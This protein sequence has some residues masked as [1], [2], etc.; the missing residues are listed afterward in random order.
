MTD[1]KLTDE[2]LLDWIH[3]ELKDSHSALNDWRTEAEKCYDM[4]ASKQWDEADEKQLE[5]NNRV[6]VTFNRIARTINAVAG[7]EIQNRQEIRYYPRQL[8][9][10]GVNAMLTNAA[11]WV[12]DR[13][14]AEDEESEMFSDCL[15]TGMGWIEYPLEDE[16]KEINV[17]TNRL[18]P[19]EML[20]DRKAKKKNLVDSLWRAKLKSISEDDLIERWPDADLGK[21][22]EG[23][24]YLE[25]SI[26][27]RDVTPPRYRKE[28]EKPESARLDGY[29]VIEFQW[30]ENEPYYQVLTEGGQIAE[31]TPAKWDKVKKYAEQRGLRWNKRKRKVFQCAYVCGRALLQREPVPSQDDFTLQCITGLR[32]RNT[33]TWFGLVTLMRDPQRWANKWLSQILHIVNVNAKGGLLAEAD[34]FEDVAKAEA[35][36][37]ASDTI[38]WMRQGGLQKIQERSFGQ[39]PPGVD[40]LLQYALQA[41]TDVP[42]VNAEMLGLVDRDQPGIL[43]EARKRA[44]ITIISMFFDA[45]RRYRKAAGHVLAGL[46]RDYIADGRLIRILGPQGEQYVP[47]IRDPLTAEY[48]IVVDESP[49]S[50][51]MK[52][53]A[54]GAL[55]QI[56]PMAIQAGIRVPPE[57]IDYTPLPESLIAKWKEL[58]SPRQPDPK[59]AAEAEAMKQLSFRQLSANAAETEAKAQYLLAQ[60][61]EKMQSAGLQGA[62][63]AA[64]ERNN[65]HELSI[66]SLKAQHEIQMLR[67]KTISE[68][69][70]EFQK[71]HAQHVDTQ[72]KISEH[73]AKLSEHFAGLHEQMSQ[74]PEHNAHLHDLIGGLTKVMG[75]DR[76]VVRGPDG[77]AIGTH[78]VMQ[79]GGLPEPFE[80]KIAPKTLTVKNKR[81]Q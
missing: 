72:L 26:Q 18:D 11:K 64:E 31:F 35:Q 80:A 36:W 50:P 21:A 66:A 77:R 68:A 41:I 53:K 67:L 39:I 62:R 49:S 19:L 32:N 37:G 46:I 12:R 42:G 56:L 3:E 43:E 8:G 16:G 57:V 69:A 23:T 70:P 14:E 7:V 55:M 9:A 52:D 13:A 45:L 81:L 54:F 79:G 40:K 48:D 2:E 28:N 63:I 47:L 1:S 58:I 27:P 59:A 34:A 22:R 20:W 30:F 44:G 4:Y 15:I 29:E 71:M 17:G 73:L 65:A 10:A 38:V 76:K 60:A 24:S 33:N 51:S 61:Q 78:I 6:A 74:R 75:A 5:E 25:Y